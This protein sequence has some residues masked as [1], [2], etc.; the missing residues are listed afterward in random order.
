MAHRRVPV[1]F[2]QQQQ[3]Q[4]LTFLCLCV[5]KGAV[6]LHLRKTN[7]AFKVIRL[8]VLFIVWFK[9]QLIV[10]GQEDSQFQRLSH[11]TFFRPSKRLV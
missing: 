2:T 4:Q 1:L 3:Q 5:I 9:R 6:T 10:C 8:F 11:L 7:G